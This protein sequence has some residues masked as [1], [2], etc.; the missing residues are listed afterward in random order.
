MISC[1]KSDTKFPDVEV[2]FEFNGLREKHIYDGF[3]PVHLLS[4]QIYTSGVHHYFGTE[5]IPSNGSVRGTITFITP[6]AYAHCLSIGS[7]IPIYDLPNIIGHATVIQI[8]NPILA[9]D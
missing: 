5:S 9:S 8:F 2:F 1:Q 7:V 6:E 3:R 4:D